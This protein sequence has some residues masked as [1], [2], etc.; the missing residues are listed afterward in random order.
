MMKKLNRNTFDFENLFGSILQGLILDVFRRIYEK[1]S[2]V[3]KCE[4]KYFD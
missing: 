2:F 3:L 4:K 1:F